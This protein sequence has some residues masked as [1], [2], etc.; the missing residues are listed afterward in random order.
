LKFS[1]LN[2]TTINDAPNVH[3]QKTSM[4]A[5]SGRAHSTK[6][7]NGRVTRNDIVQLDAQRPLR[8]FHALLEEAEHLFMTNLV[9]R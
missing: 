4:L 5:G 1:K 9:A 3:L 8:Q 7:K 2:R 6:D